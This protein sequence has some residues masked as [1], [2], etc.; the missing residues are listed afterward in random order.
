M[1]VPL[2]LVGQKVACPTCGAGLRVRSPSRPP[3][4][5]SRMTSPP[6]AAPAAMP[7]QAPAPMFPPVPPPIPGPAAARLGEVF[8]ERMKANR[9]L[10]GR[11]CSS[12]GRAVELGDDVY[13]C[14][15]CR[16]TMHHGCFEQ[17]GGCAN[18]QCAKSV[19][20]RLAPSALPGAPLPA[21]GMAG[22]EEELVECKFCR[23]KIKKK[24]IKCR[25]CGE[26][27]GAARRAAEAS[28]KQ[29]SSEDDNLSG[30]EIA[31]GILCG[32]LACILGIVWA[33]QGKKKGWKLVALGVGS[34]IVWNL[35]SLAIRS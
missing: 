29:K 33:I 12:C 30:A 15:A 5:P 8:P 1:S 34:A 2:D 17:A 18:V 10:A 21:A 6:A 19:A 28:K 9:A 11:T 35:I 25:F 16:T 22:P 32:G 27:Q 31:F 26:L 4:A 3:A 20:L 14:P 13:N 23:E 24:A 7:P